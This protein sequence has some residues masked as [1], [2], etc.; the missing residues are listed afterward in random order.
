MSRTTVSESISVSRFDASHLS[1]PLRAGRIQ[2][3]NNP[4]DPAARAEDSK[5]ISLGSPV[6]RRTREF[7]R[8][9]PFEVLRIKM[10]FFVI[11]LTL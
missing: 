1:A 10:F 6:S 2:T 4:Q 9:R 5:S 8:S 3:T 7:G 11:S